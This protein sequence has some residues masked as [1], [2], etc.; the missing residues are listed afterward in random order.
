MSYI[1]GKSCVD[2]MDTACANVCPVDCIHGPISIDG[3]GSEIARDGRDAFPGG[4]MYINRCLYQKPE[5]PVTAIYEDETLATKA[6]DVESIH[7]NYEFF[8]L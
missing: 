5:C 7:K 6:G 3:A 1:I 4:Q 2:C 8:G